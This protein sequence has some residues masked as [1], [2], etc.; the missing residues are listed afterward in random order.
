MTTIAYRRGVVATDKQTTSNGTISRGRCKAMLFDDAVYC[1]TGTLV[2]GIKFIKWLRSEQTDNA[3]KLKST[4]VLEMSMKTGKACLW[5]DSVPLPIEDS[6]WAAGSGGDLALGAMAQGA[7]PEEAVR[8][9]TR[10]D[11]GTGKGVQIFSSKAALLREE[12]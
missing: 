2:R 9:A 7:S 4:V 10:Y 1:I 3:P 11:D 12:L 5:E 6:I 8:I